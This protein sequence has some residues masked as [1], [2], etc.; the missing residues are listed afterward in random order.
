[1]A[2]SSPSRARLQATAACAGSLVLWWRIGGAGPLGLVGF[3]AT[4]ALLAWISPSR[5][6]PVQRV[7]DRLVQS[8]MTLLTWAVLGLVYFGLFTPLRF[9]RALFRRDPLR[10]RRAPDA[11]TYLQPL[12]PATPARFDR[13]F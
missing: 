5:Y 1:M 4:L 9:W 11:A 8:V 10:L 6:A 7:L 3:A 12:R 13:Q 2:P